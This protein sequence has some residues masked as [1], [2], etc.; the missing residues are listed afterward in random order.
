MKKIELI[1]CL[2]LAVQST[3]DKFLGKAST[4]NLTI[5]NNDEDIHH[6]SSPSKSKQVS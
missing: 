6:H 5:N 1:Y 3:L 4:I 2:F